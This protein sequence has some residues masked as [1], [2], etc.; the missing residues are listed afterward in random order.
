MTEADFDEF[1]DMLDA[2]CSMLSRGTYTPNAT[3]IALFFR[4]LEEYDLATVRAAFA[5]HVKDPRR[6]RYVPVP[7]DII[8]KIQMLAMRLSLCDPYPWSANDE[9]AE[10]DVRRLRDDCG[11]S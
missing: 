7:A 10:P 11:E 3:A 9:Q 1:A 2:V 6:G 5:A 8:A 4:S